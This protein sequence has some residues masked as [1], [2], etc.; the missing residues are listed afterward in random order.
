MPFLPPVARALLWGPYRPPEEVRERMH[1]YRKTGMTLPIITPAVE[2]EGSVE[3]AMEVL[4]A[5]APP[6]TRVGT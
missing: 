6:A 5:R 4:H 3:Q 1:A 2:P